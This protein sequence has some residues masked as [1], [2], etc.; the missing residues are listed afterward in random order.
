MYLHHRHAWHHLIAGALIGFSLASLSTPLLA[1]ASLNE[2]EMAK[3]RWTYAKQK[4]KNHHAHVWKLAYFEPYSTDDDET[5]YYTIGW[6]VKGKVHQTDVDSHSLDS[7]REVI[8]A[9]L[10][11]PYVVKTS[12]GHSTWYI[13]RPPYS[14]LYNAPD[15]GINGK[16][17]EKSA[18]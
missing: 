11:T 13:H 4:R 2:N 8:D 14:T 16:V 9:N 7:F 1:H 12:G 3:A 10:D 15:S 17:V 5:S 6:W 18:Q